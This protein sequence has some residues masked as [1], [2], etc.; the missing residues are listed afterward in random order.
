MQHARRFCVDVSILGTKCVRK[1]PLD[2][3]D[4]G[5]R[6]VRALLELFMNQASLEDLKK[7]ILRC[8]PVANFLHPDEVRDG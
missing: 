4:V 3:V 1:R 6:I 2:K 8:D 5:L 7:R